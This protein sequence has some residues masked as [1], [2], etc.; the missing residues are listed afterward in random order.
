MLYALPLRTRGTECG[1]DRWVTLPAIISYMEHCRWR[2]MEEPELG[3]IEAVHAGHGFYVVEQSIAMS[4]RF[5][6]GIDTQVRC[7][8]RRVGRSVAEG[9][10]DVVRADGV[11]LARCWIKGT[12]MGPTGHMARIPSQA[13]EAVHD[14]ALPSER[15][16]DEPGS[17]HSLFDPPR[18]LRPEADDLPRPHARPEGAVACAMQVRSADLDIFDHVNAANYVRFVA[19]A[20]EVRGHSPSLHRAEL[21]YMGQARRGDTV[22]VY[23]WPLGGERW[24]AEIVRGE[25]VLFRATVQTEG[26]LG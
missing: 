15:G 2:W 11:R 20:L 25:G 19:H 4:R 21:Q 12:W 1:P 9:E 24:G 10:Q 23:T 26:D 7:A 16:E 22:D 13:R 3:L 14:R 8:L 18:P 6:Q 5:G 17:P